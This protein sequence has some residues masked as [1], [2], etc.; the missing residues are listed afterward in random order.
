MQSHKPFDGLCVPGFVLLDNKCITPAECKAETS[1]ESCKP[2]KDTSYLR[3]GLQGKAGIPASSVVCAPSFELVFKS[4]DATPACV[5]SETV[6]KLMERGWQIAKPAIACTL[7]WNPVCGANGETYGNMCALRSEHVELQYKGECIVDE[8]PTEFE[9]D[10]RLDQ[11][12]SRIDDISSDIYNG[13]Y[14]GNLSLPQVLEKLQDARFEM[15]SLHEQY[16]NLDEEMKSD[17]EIAQRFENLGKIGFAS[18]DSRIK[19]LQRQIESSLPEKSPGEIEQQM[20]RSITIRFQSLSSVIKNYESSFQDDKYV[21][22]TD[23]QFM[24]D[25]LMKARTG[26]SDLEHTLQDYSDSVSESLYLKVSKA[27]PDMRSSVNNMLETIRNQ[28]N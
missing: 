7:E 10:K 9:L 16:N 20:E 18:V 4:H 2:G 28:T 26:V 13:Q 25:L 17:L 15:K 24:E 8:V 19:M 14:H 27:I 5:K 22:D 3:P 1:T 21:G 6:S 23:P 11:I 12:Q